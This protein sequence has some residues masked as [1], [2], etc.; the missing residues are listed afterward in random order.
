[1][2]KQKDKSIGGFGK[3]EARAKCGIM[4]EQFF[5]SDSYS[6][7]DPEERT[8]KQ[9]RDVLVD[10]RLEQA[11]PNRLDLMREGIVA[12]VITTVN[13]DQ[14]EELFQECITALNLKTVDKIERRLTKPDDISR[15]GFRKQ[16][17]LRLI[18]D[19]DVNN[20][21]TQSFLNLTKED[22]K[23]AFKRIRL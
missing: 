16:I 4:I 1:M 23:N 6:I 7:Y 9:R 17:K 21:D 8:I 22:V 10:E 12:N 13:E 18:I 11:S 15:D 3:L 20:F 14:T 19:S 2:L 5:E